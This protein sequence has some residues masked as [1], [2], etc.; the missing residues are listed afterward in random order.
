MHGTVIT[1]LVKDAAKSPDSMNNLRPISLLDTIKRLVGRII[2]DRLSK[3]AEAKGVFTDQQFGFRHHHSTKMA[4]ARL[5]ASFQEARTRRSRLVVAYLDFSNM[6]CTIPHSLIQHI[7][8]VQGFSARD[9]QLIKNLYA[10]TASAVRLPTGT[11]AWIE[12]RSGVMQ[13]APESCPIANLVVGALVRFLQATP[14]VGFVHHRGCREF[15]LG[16][17][18]DLCLLANST[19]AMAALLAQVELFCSRTGLELNVAK[20]VVHICC[21]TGM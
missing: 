9:I 14:R 11:S 1:L 8:T 10:G 6:Y 13:G 12:N 7:M 17:A 19:E 21:F 20:T 3:A 5:H 18:D 2:T 16:Y 4:I 15:V